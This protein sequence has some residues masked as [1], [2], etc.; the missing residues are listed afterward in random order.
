MGLYSLLKTSRFVS[1]YRFSDIVRAA[2]SDP[3]SAAVRPEME[4]QQ[5]V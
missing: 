2:K 4:F 5:T 1:G 3:A